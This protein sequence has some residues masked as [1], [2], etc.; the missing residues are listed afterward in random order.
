MVESKRKDTSN[1]LQKNGT[2]RGNRN[3]TVPGKTFLQLDIITRLQN[4]QTLNA[5]NIFYKQLQLIQQQQC[6]SLNILVFCFSK[7]Q[8]IY[9]YIYYRNLSQTNSLN[10]KF[11]LDNCLCFITYILFFIVAH[12]GVI[13]Y[14]LLTKWTKRHECILFIVTKFLSSKTVNVNLSRCLG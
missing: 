1:N 8:I 4:S 9:L 10:V 11:C 13:R 3:F 12:F 2:L 5:N 14:F 6:N 7:F